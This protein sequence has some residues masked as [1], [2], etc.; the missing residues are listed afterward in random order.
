MTAGALMAGVIF[1]AIGLG[2]WIYGKKS[3][4][5]KAKLIG[6]CLMIYPLFVWDTWPLV[7]IGSL[8]TAALFVF[9]D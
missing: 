2:A 3:D 9:R 4:S 6:F 7:L 1:S 5:W 8:L